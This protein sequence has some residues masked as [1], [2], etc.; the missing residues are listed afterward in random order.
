MGQ[1]TTIAPA[2]GTEFKDRDLSWFAEKVKQGESEIY[3]EVVTVTPD[4]ARRLLEQNVDNRNY[5][6]RQIDQIAHDIVRGHWDING[7]AI[8]VSKDGWLN[9]GQNRLFGILK[10]NQ[11]VRSLVVF[12]VTRASRMT[13]DMGRAR[14]PSQYL[15]MEQVV[16]ANEC[17]A[18]A[19]QWAAFELNYYGKLS[20]NKSIGITKQDV[21]AF[22][23]S[24]KAKIDA[25]VLNIKSHKNMKFLGKGGRSAII[26]AYLIIRDT[27]PIH[28]DTFMD[29]FLDGANLDTD[30]PILWLR[31]RMMTAKNLT[32]YNKIEY[33]L[34]YWMKWKDNI[35]MHKHLTLEETWPDLNK[36][37]VK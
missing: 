16:N 11:P 3:A 1:A 31:N 25:G 9:D 7:E 29:Q 18:I 5:N 21:L 15:L 6:Q 14:T 20:K 36:R 35:K 8:I 22:Y 23:H 4:I 26:T 17:S 12:G 32:S 33:M 19:A 13:V 10:A 24:K 34:R 27:D 37:K 30:S 2:K 28:A